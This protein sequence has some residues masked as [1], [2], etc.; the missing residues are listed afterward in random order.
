VDSNHRPHDYECAPPYKARGQAGIAGREIPAN[1]QLKAEVGWPRAAACFCARGP[2]VDP[3]RCAVNV[4]PVA[5]ACPG[6]EPVSDGR[7]RCDRLRI[8]G[9]VFHRAR[10]D[11]RP[12]WTSRESTAARVHS[13]I[14]D[15]S[16]RPTA[17]R[18]YASSSS[19]AGGDRVPA[20][21][22]SSGDWR[23]ERGHTPKRGDCSVRREA[24]LPARAL[25]CRPR[26]QQRPARRA[27]AC[28]SLRTSDV[29][30]GSALAEVIEDESAEDFRLKRREMPRLRDDD[31]PR[32]AQLLCEHLGS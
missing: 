8:V 11:T 30:P 19:T 17:R 13:C 28:A 9:S 25:V 4:P 12:R 32:L 21:V 15:V 20:R 2:L 29:W 14:A 3:A 31:D 7:D 26:R 18:A 22:P 5:R 1:E 6:G 23:S 16:G 10:L 24:A 27:F